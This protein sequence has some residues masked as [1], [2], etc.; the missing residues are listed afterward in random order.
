M[1]RPLTFLHE[2]P[3]SSS[4]VHA[5]SEM[6]S[7]QQTTNG[8]R[9]CSVGLSCRPQLSATEVGSWHTLV[10]CINSLVFA[11]GSILT[12]I[13]YF[14]NARLISLCP[15]PTNGSRK[16]AAYLQ[17][18][19]YTPRP[20]SFLGYLSEKRFAFRFSAKKRL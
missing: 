10:F 2:A 13:V 14:Y 17:Y 7:R 5:Y 11:I 19:R 8:K 15:I 18:L 1:H 9:P 12:I 6:S 4:L 3:H 16:K 20:T